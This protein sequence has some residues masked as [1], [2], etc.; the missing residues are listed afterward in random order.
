M[1]RKELNDKI[2]VGVIE[3][4]QDPNKLGR[5]R[6]R[7]FNVFDDISVEDIPW[8]TPWKDLNG[9]QFILPDKGKVVSVVFDEGNIYKPEYI[10]AEHYN[11][12]LEKKLSELSGSNYTSMRALMFDHKTQIYSNDEEGLKLDYKFNNVNITE[13]TI[14]VNLKD[15]FGKVNIGSPTCDQQAILGNHF[16]NWFDKFINTIVINGHLGNLAAP[17]VPTPDMLNILS[18]YYTLRNPKFLSHHVSIVDNNYVVKQDRIADGQIGDNW[19]STVTE[20]DS[21]SFEETNDYSP[22]PGLTTDAPEGQLSVD[23]DNPDLTPPEPSAT[24]PTNHPDV[25]AIIAT[26][27]R[28][29][30]II[31]SKPYQ[32]NIIGIRRQYEGMAYSNQFVDSLVVF[33]KTTADGTWE[34]WKCPF[35]TL[36]GVYLGEQRDDLRDKNNQVPF[37]PQGWNH[38]DGSKAKAVLLNKASTRFQV[39]REGLGQLQPSQMVDKYKLGTYLNQPALLDNGNLPV[40]RDKLKQNKIEYTIKTVGAHYYFHRS[41][42]N[43]QI[44]NNW[45][46]GCQV[47]Q[48]WKDH[49]YFIK[50]CRQH[51]KKHGNSFTYT[52]IEERDIQTES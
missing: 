51:E 14:D 5:C 47:F 30:Y 28:K 46:E 48:T 37:T 16:L 24:T 42:P 35:T 26:M 11:T 2:F 18:E 20:N 45:S 21:A 31:Y 43:S 7:V 8:A 36:P 41:G 33:Y 22:K 3:D 19:N 29:K 39:N 44:V 15:N 17:I 13:K 4:N 23:E 25:E 52:L 9:N 12:N 38:P 32:L 27:Q 50:L 40:Y 1:T 34:I 49:E 6:V 10:Y